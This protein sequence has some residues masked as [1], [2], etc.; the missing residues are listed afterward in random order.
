M[1]LVRLIR[2]DSCGLPEIWMNLERESLFYSR[3]RIKCNFSKKHA[4]L[5]LRWPLAEPEY[6]FCYIWV[7]RTRWPCCVDESSLWQGGSESP[8]CHFVQPQFHFDL[9]SATV[10]EQERAQ[11]QQWPPV[12][13]KMATELSPESSSRE[14]L[15]LSSTRKGITE[16]SGQHCS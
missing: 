16:G 13:D 1:D 4:W 2:K 9:G 7:W 14:S 6:T 15:C 3:E 11:E 12:P 10:Q 5:R 8:T